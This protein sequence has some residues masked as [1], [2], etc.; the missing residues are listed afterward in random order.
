MILGRGGGGK[1]DLAF[2]GG[3]AMGSGSTSTA[4]GGGAESGDGVPQSGRGTALRGA[5]RSST[6]RRTSTPSAAIFFNRAMASLLPWRAERTSQ[7]T[8][9]SISRL[10]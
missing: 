4:G 10:T 5:G 1:T 9:S 7:T 2:A 6:R 8:A 3:A